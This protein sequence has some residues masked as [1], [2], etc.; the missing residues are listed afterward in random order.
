MLRDIQLLASRRAWE[1]AA[2]AIRLSMLTSTGVINAVRESFQFSIAQVASP[3]E[4]FG[5]IPAVIPPG[6]VFNYGL[7]PYTPEASAGVRFLHIEPRRVVLDISG[8]SAALQVGYDGL[9]EILSELRTTE[10]D[11]VIGEP[12]RQLDV[13]EIRYRMDADLERLVI[14]EAW[15]VLRQHLG[16]DDSSIRFSPSLI[17]SLLPSNELFQG[18][19]PQASQQATL[20]M[21]FGTE[22]GDG[23]LFSSA[24]L[25]SD[26][27]IEMLEALDRA[28]SA[29]E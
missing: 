19:I 26:A 22:P 25:T 15:Q 3:M 21:R 23:V 10:G 17:T 5:P 28:L 18:R 1:F 29:N 8:P 9:R 7:L 12:I 4:T 20:E 16:P 6:L 2:D 24:P 27:H 14:P 11:P 13:S